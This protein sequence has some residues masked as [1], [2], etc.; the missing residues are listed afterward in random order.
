MI[1]IADS[2]STKTDWR[3][4]DVDGK[5]S[6]AKTTGFNP[7]YMSEKEIGDALKIELI[8]QLNGMPTTVFFY[9]AG[10]STITNKTVI[11]NAIHSV[12]PETT[13]EVEHDLLAAA[14]ALCLDQEGIACILGTGSNSC[15][16]D[17]KNIVENVPSLGYVLGD[18]GSGAFLG[19]KLLRDYLRKDVPENIA[20]KLDQRFHLSEED[21]LSKTYK[22]ST[23]NRFMASFA[24]FIFH[25]L[26]EPYLY[27]LVQE[28]FV[29]F[30]E[31]NVMRYSKHQH[32]NVHFTGAVAFYFSN[33]LRQVAAEK[34]ITVKH[35]TESPIAGLTLYHQKQILS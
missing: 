32:C 6:Q 21:I 20:Q 27:S 5:I 34:N 9:G 15:Y 14:R 28:S 29:D 31:N 22:E 8:P 24:Q 35:I 25:N 23:P 10:C 4:L 13:V 2:G 16:Y 3:Y 18:E 30:F 33:I 12:W 17:G 19:K 1:L 11:S 26:K 7:Y